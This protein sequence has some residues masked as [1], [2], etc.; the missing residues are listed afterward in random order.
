MT[1]IIFIISTILGLPALVVGILSQIEFWQRKEYRTDRALAAL[2]SFELSNSIRAYFIALIFTVIGWL[3][4][5]SWTN[6][7]K[8]NSEKNLETQS[9][10]ET[11]TNA[12]VVEQK[13]TTDNAEV[14]IL[15]SEGN[16]IG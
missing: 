11:D 3:L 1:S 8:N 2:K 10:D 7:E 6:P 16:H 9:L 14:F 15:S 12:P 13:D 4:E 5:K